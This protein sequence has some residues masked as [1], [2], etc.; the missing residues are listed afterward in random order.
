LKISKVR[1]RLT[2]KMNR[3]IIYM[4]LSDGFIAR[5]GNQFG[6]GRCLGQMRW[7]GFSAAQPGDAD[8]SPCRSAG[9]SEAPWR[10]N[11]RRYPKVFI[12]LPVF[13]RF[14]KHLEFAK[15]E[16]GDEQKTSFIRKGG[17]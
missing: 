1:K 4:Q 13:A 3:I 12:P 14:L 6:R 16:D 8:R 5:L 17:A 11:A 2:R 10:G 7:L 15:L 9:V